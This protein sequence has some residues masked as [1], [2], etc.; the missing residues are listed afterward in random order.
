MSTSVR[1]CYIASPNSSL[2][3]LCCFACENRWTADRAQ[4]QI[5]DISRPVESHSG[6]RK[7]ILVGPKHLRGPLWRNFFLNFSFQNGA[8]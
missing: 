1:V 3:L 5:D 2:I 8:L 6:D 7:N 4:W